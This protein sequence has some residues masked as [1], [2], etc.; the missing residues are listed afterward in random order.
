MIEEKHKI[1]A[2]FTH[3]VVEKNRTTVQKLDRQ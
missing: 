2:E 3:V 1:L